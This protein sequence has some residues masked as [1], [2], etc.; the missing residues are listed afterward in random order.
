[1]IRNPV[2]V[3]TKDTFLSDAGQCSPCR[4]SDG[5]DTGLNLH[6]RA[7]FIRRTALILVI[8]CIVPSP[9]A[10]GASTSA[11]SA[12]AA[13]TDIQQP[14]PSL[15]FV[16]A[17]SSADDVRRSHPVLD[18]TLDIIAGSKDPVP[19]ADK[20]RSPSAVTTDSNHRVFVAD[21][22]SKAVGV[23][24]FARSKY[25]RLE[26]GRGHPFT[27]ISLAVDGHAN[28]YVIDRISRTVLIYDSTGKFSGYLGK[29]TG[30]E[31]YFESPAGITIDR[32]TGRIYV[33]DT[34]RHMVIIMDSQGQLI[35]KIGKRGGGDQ[36][37]EFKLPGQLVVAG[38][39]LIVL[40][41]GNARIQILDA[42]GQFRRAINLPFADNRTGLAVDNQSNIYVSNPELHEIWVFSH[43]GESLY[44]FDPTTI[45][46]A[47][48]S[49]PLAMW[50]DSGYCL[51]VVDS[52]SNRV[53]L[54]QISGQ[55]APQCQ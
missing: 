51:Y 55:N 54:F 9:G 34:L 37:G 5:I 36:P 16:R 21:P 27:P 23:F 26:G 25:S 3:V 13:Q 19:G 45:E 2:T 30:G 33:S 12:P 40:D 1:M 42:D 39:E 29:L 43:A 44:I 28:L 6:P 14:S 48:F 4:S 35:R 53:G 41:A 31:S 52:Q 15:S 24:D 17:F 20:M 7:Q 47:N 11:T 46:G 10:V 8:C 18:R 32:A 22:L 50:V 38:G 49:H